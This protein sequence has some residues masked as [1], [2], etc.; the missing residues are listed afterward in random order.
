MALGKRDLSRKK[1]SLEDKLSAVAGRARKSP[2]KK[3]LQD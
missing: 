1:M 2:L 3:K